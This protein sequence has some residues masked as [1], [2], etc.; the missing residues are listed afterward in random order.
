MSIFAQVRFYTYHTV[1]IAHTGCQNNGVISITRCA[2]KTAGYVCAA[3]LI[4]YGVLAKI[5]GVFLAIPNSVLGGVTTCERASLC[6]SWANK[7]DSFRS[8]LFATVFVSGLK[9]ISFAEMTRRNRIV[10][11]SSLSL[12]LGSLL[13]PDYANYMFTYTG[14]NAALKGF[15]NSIVIILSTPFLSKRFL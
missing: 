9:V 4:L 15:F 2:N 10:L 14:S 5:S 7:A 11:A 3:L 8:V 1:Q 13:V 6:T 12:G